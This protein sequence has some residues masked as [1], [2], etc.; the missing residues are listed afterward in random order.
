DLATSRAALLLPQQKASLTRPV[1]AALHNL[2]CCTEPWP[3]W[4]NLADA[5]NVA[6][7]LALRNIA[8]DRLPEIQAGQ[9][10]M[11][12]IYHRQDE[13]GTWAMRAHELDTLDFALQLHTIQL[14]LCTQGELKDSIQA[15]QRRV[16]QALAGNAPKNARVCVGQIGIQAQTNKSTQA[17]VLQ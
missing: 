11:H 7:Q 6:E 12:D 2:R 14:G 17:E 13:R 15:V 1:T 10:I 4:C 5:L 16:Q 9:K 8:S 3:A